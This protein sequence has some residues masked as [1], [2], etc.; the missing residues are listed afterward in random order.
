MGGRW[1][2]YQHG[3]ID[4]NEVSP[5][6]FEGLLLLASDWAADQEAR[7]L[8]EGEPLTE[9]QLALAR[10]VGVS[11]PQRVRLLRV[12][13]I[14]R[15]SNPALVAA[16]DATGL[17]SPYTT[18]LTIHYGIFIRADSWGD[19]RLLAHE[20]VHIRQY[21]RTGGI[22]PFLRQYLLEC[23]T[24]GYPDAPME[25]EAVQTADMIIRQE[26]EGE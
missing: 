19:V 4:M 12:E 3:G 13:Q 7:I 25:K 15:P 21:E 2:S 8:K 14:P 1:H 23:V 22:Y 11:R 6:E 16:A 24:D 10:R 5:E 18:G 20:L 17:L 9:S 26:S